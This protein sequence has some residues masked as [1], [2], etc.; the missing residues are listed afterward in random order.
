MYSLWWL[1]S[2]H[3]DIFHSRFMLNFTYYVHLLFFIRTS[4]WY[5]FFSNSNPNPNPNPNPNF[6]GAHWFLPALF[7]SML[8]H[9]VE[10]RN[11]P[12][13]FY[14]YLLSS[15]LIIFNLLVPITLV[16]HFTPIHNNSGRLGSRSRLTAQYLASLLMGF[17]SDFWRILSASLTRI[18]TDIHSYSCVSMVSCWYGFAFDVLFL[19]LFRFNDPHLYTHKSHKKC[20]NTT[21]K[22]LY[23][24]LQ[25]PLKSFKIK[26]L[27]TS[28]EQI[29]IWRRQVKNLVIRTMFSES[30]NCGGYY[31]GW[32]GWV[33]LEQCGSL[34]H[35][36]WH[37]KLL[38]LVWRRPCPVPLIQSS[39]SESTAL[40]CSTSSEIVPAKLQPRGLS[41]YSWI[42][43]PVS[44]NVR[45]NDFNSSFKSRQSCVGSSWS[46]RRLAIRMTSPT[47]LLIAK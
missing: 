46:T 17:I 11:D 22:P 45:C 1:R 27:F 12:P 33:S 8:F 39:S 34:S 43:S 2:A 47:V 18:T 9:R 30:P 23:I 20:P 40:H 36:T 21:T 13:L 41:S 31:Q 19:F 29:I 7:V 4:F 35:Q 15:F 42:A 37:H 32:V 24:T 28:L 6:V 16:D 3:R 10:Q 14:Y 5:S 25:M 38:I 44:V 26:P